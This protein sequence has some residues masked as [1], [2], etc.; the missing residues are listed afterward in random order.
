MKV[1][2]TPLVFLVAYALTLGSPL[3]A[4]GT[5]K[6]GVGRVAITPEKNIWMA[7]YA[8]RNKPAEGKLHDLYVKALTFEDETGARTVLV[9]TDIVGY[10]ADISNKVA[11]IVEDRFDIPRERLMLTASHTHSGP[12]IR[13]NLI[14]MYEIPQDQIELVEEYLEGFPA[15][16][17]KAI[18]ESLENLEPC[19]LR[20]GIGSTG[21]AVNRRQYTI[22]GVINGKNPIGPVDH[23]V[24]VLSIKREDGS[25]KAIAFGYACHNTVLG[26]YQWNGDYAG[27]AQAYLETKMPGTVAL[28]ANGC[29]GD[30][31][32]LPRKKIE[33][34]EKYGKELGEAVLGVL[35]AEM[36][37]VTGPIL[38]V[39]E[40]IPLSLNEQPSREDLE[41]QLQDPNK[42]VRRRAEWSLAILEEKGALQAEI[43]YPV[44]IW[45]FAD[46]LQI[47]SLGGEVCVDYSLRLKHELGREK[48]WVIAYAND[49]MAYIPSLRVLY[50]GGY[51]GGDA[52]VY[53]GLHGTWKPETE[54]QII[55]AVHRLSEKASEPLNKP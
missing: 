31:N 29:G 18:E 21:F 1:L 32:P 49:V 8:S 3:L 51:E 13:R 22:D 34:A 54:Q 48:Q 7:G 25:T 5:L 24:P 2:T 17:A 14:G 15:L 52:M 43:P 37:E 44:Q 4:T 16:V 11:G 55:D 50:E 36:A 12:V 33:L 41:K 40:E 19:S 26:I 35:G 47:T 53:F 39:Y 30:I 27:F 42:Y 6:V 9:T 45:R 23:D 46:T 38:A 28:F 10:V 20:W